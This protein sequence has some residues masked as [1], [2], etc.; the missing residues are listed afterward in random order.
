[1]AA[2]KFVVIMAMCA[3]YKCIGLQYSECIHDFAA[4]ICPDKMIVMLLTTL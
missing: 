4:V 2:A 1:M 3:I